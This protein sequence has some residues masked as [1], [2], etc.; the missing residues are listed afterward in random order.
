VPA[1][2]HRPMSVASTAATAVKTA[3]TRR[4][5]PWVRWTAPAF[6]PD[7]STTRINRSALAAHAL[8][9]ATDAPAEIAQAAHTPLKHDRQMATASAVWWAKQRIGGVYRGES[10]EGPARRTAWRRSCPPRARTSL[11][12]S[13]A[14]AGVAFIHVNRATQLLAGGDRL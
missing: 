1:M 4:R 6:R 12:S 14:R 5:E 3:R 10:W 11:R 8:L 13:P 9:Q 2:T 7:T